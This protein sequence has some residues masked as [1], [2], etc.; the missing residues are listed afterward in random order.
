M[1]HAQQDS[2]LVFP[3]THPKGLAYVLD[4]RSDGVATVAASSV[5]EPE[6]ANA[7]GELVLLPFVH[8]AEFSRAL[9]SLVEQRCISRIYAPVAAVHAWLKRFIAER[10]LKL[11]LIGES[12]ISTEMLRHREVRAAATRLARFVHDCAGSETSVSQLELS[13]VLQL[14]SQFYGESNEQKIAALVAI[15]A[16]TPHGDVIE[17][18]ALA[19]K[20]AAVLAWLARR[21]GIGQVLAIDPWSAGEATQ[22]DSPDTVRTDLVGEWDYELLKDD[23]VCNVLPVG[24]GHLNYLRAPSEAAHAV[25]A[26]GRS[27]QSPEFGSSDYSGRIALLH[28]DGNH[29]YAHARQDCELW[30]PHLC[31]DGW[32][33][34][35]DYVWM[36]GDGPQRVGNELLLRHADL[37]ERAFVCG[38]ALF[39]KFSAC[40]AG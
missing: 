19:G 14:S 10:G 21:Y 4:R 13:S 37:I 11:R 18:G 30:L 35:D 16:D 17:I 9:L 22:M 24:Y 7:V 6:A 3:A 26:S 31:A 23:F 8:E 5:W 39:V 1:T 36:H 28:V 40:P 33:V 25:Y 15:A 20:S 34:L 32:L 29:D 12:P 38:K 27:V 2:T